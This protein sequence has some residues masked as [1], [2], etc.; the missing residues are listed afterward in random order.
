MKPFPFL[1]FFAGGGMARLG[2]GEGWRCVFANDLDSK[3]AVTY[4]KNFPPADE[5]IVEDVAKL[6]ANE[7]PGAPVLAWASFPCQDLSL[8]GSRQGL[9]GE[10]SGTFWSFSQLITELRNDGRRVPLLVLE[11]V[12]GALTSHDGA[13]FRSII[14]FL[15][16]HYWVG[17][18]VIDAVHFVPQSRPRLFIVALD[19]SCGIPDGVRSPGRE[20]MWHTAAIHSAWLSLSQE[21]KDSWVWWHLPAPHPR[22]QSLC[23]I[24]EETPTGVAW[25]TP[26]ETQHILSLMSQAHRLRVD[27]ARQ[28]GYKVVGAVYRRT[29]PTPEGKRQR[30]EVRFDDISGCLR[31][32]TGGSSRQ[33]LLIVE[34][35]V[36]RSRL[37]SVREAA[38][39]MGVPESYVL[40]EAYNDGYH[41][42]GDG[43][44][45]PVV[46]WLQEHLLSPLATSVSGG[47]IAKK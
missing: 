24:L 35:G 20:D 38:R 17:A 45:V 34:N 29:R 47:V 19:K 14:G 26:E 11:N 43:L 8:A 9:R 15:S 13:D 36:V 37:L 32:P 40:P 18:L 31:T 41:L 33:T 25:H 23:D 4:R 12:V 28:V 27:G 2:L 42:M 16:Q 22:T 39:L 1:E 6:S 46:A 3:K 7:V 10:R 44:V 30:A 5:L 21:C